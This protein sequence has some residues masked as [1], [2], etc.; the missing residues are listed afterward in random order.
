MLDPSLVVLFREGLGDKM[1]ALSYCSSTMH[2][3]LPA[4]LPAHLCHVPC[5]DGHKL[6]SGTVNEALN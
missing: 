2:A 6:T 4:C 5:H 3:C 1:E